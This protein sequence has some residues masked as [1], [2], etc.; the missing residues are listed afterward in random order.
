MSH[1]NGYSEDTFRPFRMNCVCGHPFA[2]VTEMTINSGVCDDCMARMRVRD[3]QRE[4]S[5]LRNMSPAER[6]VESA[7]LAAVSN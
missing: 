1:Y 7:V 6:R 5:R 2:D 4:L 3:G